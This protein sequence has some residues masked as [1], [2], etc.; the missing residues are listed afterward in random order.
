MHVVS[1]E[2]AVAMAVSIENPADCEMRGVIGFLQTDEILRYLPEEAS[3]RVE[4][5]CLHDNARPHIARKTQALL[6]EIFE[7]PP[8]SPDLAPSDFFLFPKMKE[9]LAGKSFANDEDPKDAG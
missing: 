8:F 9:H 3:S 5:L 6:R 4:L 1:A 2:R 7:H